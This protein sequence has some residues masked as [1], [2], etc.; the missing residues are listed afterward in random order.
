MNGCAGGRATKRM[1]D[2]GRDSRFIVAQGGQWINE[3]RMRVVRIMV[4]R[5]AVSGRDRRIMRAPPPRLSMSD[6]S[7]FVRLIG[8]YFLVIFHPDLQ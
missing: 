4:A 7:L 8:P 3:I 1:P 5:P 2:K 6:V